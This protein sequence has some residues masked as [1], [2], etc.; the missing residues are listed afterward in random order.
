MCDLSG[1]QPVVLTTIWWWQKSGETGN[2]ETTQ[3]SQK[4]DIERLTLRKLNEV[5]SKEQYYV[6]ISVFIPL[7]DNVDIDGA[8]QTIRENIQI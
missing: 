3:K 5:E 2:K 8:C 4:F 6:E 7:G 1:E